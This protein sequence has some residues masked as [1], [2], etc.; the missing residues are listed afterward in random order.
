[1]QIQYNQ[2]LMAQLGANGTP[3]I[4]YLNKDKLLQQIVGL[5]NPEQMADLVACK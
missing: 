3:A 4:Y 5:P 1:K 2:Q